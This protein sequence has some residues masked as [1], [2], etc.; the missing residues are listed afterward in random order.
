MMMMMICLFLWSVEGHT[1]SPKSSVEDSQARDFKHATRRQQNHVTDD[2]CQ[3]DFAAVNNDKLQQLFI[4]DSS[5]PNSA[6]CPDS[7]HLPLKLPEFEHFLPPLS[8]QPITELGGFSDTSDADQLETERAD[9][10]DTPAQFRQNF[11]W[12]LSDKTSSSRP[13]DDRN[14]GSNKARQDD[15]SNSCRQCSD[16]S[17]DIKNTCVGEKKDCCVDSNSDISV[18]RATCL[19]VSASTAERLNSM[20]SASL[21]DL[22]QQVAFLSQQLSTQVIWHFANYIIM[23]ILLSVTDD[24]W[25]IAAAAVTLSL[26]AFDS[27]STYGAPCDG[28]SGVVRGPT[29]LPGR[30]S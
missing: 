13:H 21:S 22:L 5:C 4:P 1:N 30:R 28:G 9:F 2:L 6:N 24:I 23:W 17:A 14:H 11:A 25:L 8:V 19:A 3:I 10:Q 12:P 16:E 18:S 29:P 15:R 26:S 20:Q 27:L 7:N